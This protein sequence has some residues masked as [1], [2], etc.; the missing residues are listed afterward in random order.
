MIRHWFEPEKCFIEYGVIHVPCETSSTIVMVTTI[1]NSKQFYISMKYRKEYLHARYGLHSNKKSKCCNDK[2]KHSML[3]H[4]SCV[5][6][7]G[8]LGI[9]L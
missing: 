6:I 5:V 8:K 1:F 2:V 3:S 9:S 7:Q 4:I